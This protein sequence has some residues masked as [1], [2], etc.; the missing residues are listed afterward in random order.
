MI[1]CSAALG[2]RATEKACLMAQP[3][4]LIQL[5]LTHSKASV[6]PGI[7]YR[8]L[9]LRLWLNKQGLQYPDQCSVGIVSAQQAPC[10]RRWSQSHL[11]TGKVTPEDKQM[12]P[13]SHTLEV[14]GLESHR[15]ALQV[16]TLIPKG[17]LGG[18][19]G[20]RMGHQSLCR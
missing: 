11:Q 20:S 3:D 18:K 4:S 2:S 8:L 17:H 6:D 5:S 16:F 14:S 7:F 12:S 19:A 15:P 9:Q 1:D 13:K 10:E